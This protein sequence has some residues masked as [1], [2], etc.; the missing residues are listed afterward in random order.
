MFRSKG[1]IGIDIGSSSVKVVQLKKGAD[2]YEL[3]KAGMAPLYPDGE[4][5]GDPAV[6]RK[7]KVE[8]I[9][10]AI[11]DAGISC[12]SAVSAV[13][14]ESIIV[15]YL[16]LPNMPEEELKKALQW[17]A[18]EYI[19]FRLDEVN[20]DSMVLGKSEGG[21]DRVDV[22]LVSAK[23]E[24]VEEHV[25]IIR[26]A[27]LTPRIVDLDSFAFLNCF[28]VS[29]DDGGG[30]AVALINI[31][32]DITGICIYHKGISRFSRDISMGGGTITEAIRAHLRCSYKEA[33]VLKLTQGALPESGASG[34][35]TAPFSSSLMD[36]IRGTV[37]EMTGGAAGDS[38]TPEA[39]VS[40]AVCGV[41]NELV[42]EV[43]RSVEFFENQIRGLNV[44]RVVLGGGSCGL[45][46]MR[47]YFERELGLP[48]EL[49]DP[50]RRVRLTGK[51]LNPARLD[52]LRHSLGVG[53]GLGIRGCLAA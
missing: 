35:E 41:I 4:R 11:S 9:K 30:D 17:E 51:D 27:G 16:Q 39:Q 46:N 31:G 53:I 23:K 18:E 33:E 42:S 29:G 1:S 40:K 19:P 38:Q 8:A 12:K 13:S 10:R 14:G 6:R 34:E 36:T 50:L 15:R 5:S 45:G 44:T 26:D 24:L 2:G 25:S 22:L 32:S 52:P 7:A 28:E 47:E 21:D 3:E 49:F 20:I 43:R 37:E 48:A